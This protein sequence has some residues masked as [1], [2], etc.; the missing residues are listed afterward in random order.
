MK[1]LF[2]MADRVGA[3]KSNRYLQ[4]KNRVSMYADDV[5]IFIE[6]DVEELIAVKSL[7]QC[8]GDASGLITNYA[9]SAIIP[10]QCG[11]IDTNT[12]SMTLQCTVKV[13]PCTYLGLPLSDQRLRK[14]DLQPSLNKL[15]RKVKGWNKG[16]FSLDAR[17]LLV[18]HV[19]S[20]MHIYQLL[21]IDP[22]IWLIKAID[23]LR[24]G[25]LWNND[26]LRVENAW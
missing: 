5:V 23:K 13:F 9:K 14:G 19:L 26:E 17:L 25:F 7:L 1:A 10:I 12:L 15:S 8:F 4:P 3:L 16:N 6:P 2:T 21:V 11:H 18:K 20:A 22:H 24:M